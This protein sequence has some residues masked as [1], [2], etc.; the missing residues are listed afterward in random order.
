MTPPDEES[1]GE[2]GGVG[3]SRME[4][5]FRVW[6]GKGRSAALPRD[7]MP[8]L[9]TLLRLG[10]YDSATASLDVT[11]TEG[12][13][14][15]PHH[16]LAPLAHLRQPFHQIVLR[17]EVACELGQLGDGDTLVT[18]PLEVNRV[19]E[20]G[21]HEPEVA[22]DRRLMGKRLLDHTL[23]PVIARIDLVVE[24]DD[25]VAQLCILALD[26]TDRPSQS[27]QDDRALLLERCFERVEALLKFDAGHGYPNRPVT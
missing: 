13:Q 24:G 25:L 23:D 20:N 14:R 10:G 1:Y 22:C 21:E 19:V 9:E 11:S 12:V 4:A 2:Q 6:E 26:D 8:G 16:L 7:G 15:H 3:P 5:W 18:D 27:T 17:F